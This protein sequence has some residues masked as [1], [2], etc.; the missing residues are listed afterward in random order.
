MLVMMRDNYS[1]LEDHDEHDHGLVDDLATVRHSNSHPGS[2]AS[3]NSQGDFQI[4][5]PSRTNSSTLPAS[6][7]SD[8]IPV[9]YKGGYGGLLKRTLSEEQLLAGERMAEYRDSLMFQVRNF[10][11]KISLEGSCFSRCLQYFICR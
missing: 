1:H 6:T 2:S 9:R 4:P 8:P 10:G 11:A 5:Q 7:C 3:S